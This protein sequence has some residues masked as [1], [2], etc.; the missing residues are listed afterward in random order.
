MKLKLQK[1]I[2]MLSRYFLSGL[3][4]QTLFFNLVLAVNVNAQLKTIDQVRISLG[5]EEMTLGQFFRLVESKSE[6]SFSY[7]RND[8][9]RNF[10]VTVSPQTATVEA[11]LQQVG[12][13]ASLGF[14][15]VNDQIDVKRVRGTSTTVAILV[16]VTVRGVVRDETGAP[17]PGATVS[18]QGTT[19]GSVTDID[20]TYSITV[21]EGSTLVFSFIGYA[22]QRVQVGNQSEINITM[23]LDE[24]SLEE[25]VVVGYGTQ[26]RSD[27]TGAVSS[28]K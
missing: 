5:K 9:D 18:V 1:T 13:Q 6:F 11:L 27:L 2:Y 26:K 7:D 24:S 25:V 10:E 8:V 15:Q 22:T 19:T 16:D 20:G 3:L 4:L 12:R 21:P 17:M 28:V 23:N 14:R